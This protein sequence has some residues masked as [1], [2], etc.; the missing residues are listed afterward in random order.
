MAG[1]GP[2][3]RYRRWRAKRMTHAP[4]PWLD[5]LTTFG[6]VLLAL[7]ALSI[8]IYVARLR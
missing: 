6:I 7:G 1:M 4:R 3:R 2:V 5:G 8:A